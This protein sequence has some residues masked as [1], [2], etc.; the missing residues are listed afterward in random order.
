MAEENVV[1]P[2]DKYNR[3][4]E[5]LKNGKDDK[6]TQPTDNNSKEDKLTQ[7]ADNVTGIKPTEHVKPQHHDTTTVHTPRTRD[8]IVLKD[9][10]HPPGIKHKDIDIFMQ[11]LDKKQKSGRNKKLKTTQSKSPH[12]RKARLK[13]N[14]I[15]I[16]K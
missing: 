16:T 2:R 3:M 14:W 13:A 11:R 5:Q 1:I 6:L 8:D 12:T 7:S 4:L 9:V 10:L 15:S